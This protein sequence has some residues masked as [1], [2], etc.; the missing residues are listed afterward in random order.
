MR[1]VHTHVH[2]HRSDLERTDLDKFLPGSMRKTNGTRHF[3]RD[4][5]G[6]SCIL[7]FLDRLAARYEE[8]LPHLRSGELPFGEIN[9]ARINLCG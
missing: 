6:A 1:Q 8:T 9:Y 7:G 2:V 5:L 3:R 4:Y